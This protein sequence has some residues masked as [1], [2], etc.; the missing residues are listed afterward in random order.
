MKGEKYQDKGKEQPREKGESGKCRVYKEPR[1]TEREREENR[2]GEG[3]PA[4]REGRGKR[5]ARRNRWRKAVVEFGLR[6][7]K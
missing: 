4:E 1:E 7:E 6:A 5:E 3:R 2:E